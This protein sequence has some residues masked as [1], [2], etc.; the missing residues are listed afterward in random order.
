[1]A[2]AR[3]DRSAVSPAPPHM[4]RGRPRAAAGIRA[5]LH[6]RLHWRLTASYALVTVA[7]LAAL[8][9]FLLLAVVI[10]MIIVLGRN[11]DAI[12]G[13]LQTRAVSA[14]A[15]LLS[16]TSPDLTGIDRWLR[17]VQATG[18]VAEG[19]R[20]VEIRPDVSILARSQ[21]HLLV[22]DRNGNLAGSIKQSSAPP[23]MAP[24]APSDDHE[25][26]DAISTALAGHENSTRIL[27]WPL[28]DR[29]IVAVPVA[30]SQGE[31]VGALVFTGRTPL[32]AWAQALTRLLG[33]TAVVIILFGAVIGTVSGYLAARSLVVRFDRMSAAAAAWGT[34]DFTA[35]VAD[36]AEDEIGQLGR[37]LDRMAEQLAS[38]IRTR[39]QLSVV[40]ERNRL[41]RDLHDSVKQQAFAVSLHLGTAR[42]LFERDPAGARQRLDAAYEIARENQRELTTIIQTLRPVELADTTLPHALEHYVAE[43][44][45]RTGIAASTAIA[46]DAVFPNAVEDALFRVAQEA[47]TTVARHSRA[48]TVA[49]SLARDGDGWSLQIADDGTG[50]DTRHGRPGVGLQSMRERIETIGGRFAVAS[51]QD[52]TRISV[53]IQGAELGEG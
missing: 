20:E 15:P 2:L 6:Q 48:T 49:V 16:S 19:D 42:E 9:L 22:V 39:E 40:D 14:V 21:T 28:L 11:G 1:M 5:R 30:G 45:T 12:A 27:Q 31:V 46:P 3:R 44:R 52:G 17:E 18:I 36:G 33:T 7:V 43:W 32:D 23:A 37:R 4:G 13:D 41:A 38:L 51:D 25:L 29:L 34:G 35:A 47:L 24:A 26:G 53:H 10:G 8:E 50:F